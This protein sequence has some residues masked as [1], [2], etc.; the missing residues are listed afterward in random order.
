MWFRE[1]GNAGSGNA[2]LQLLSLNMKCKKKNYIIRMN[3]VE[4]VIILTFYNNFEKLCSLKI[5]SN[6]IIHM[7]HTTL[8]KKW[9]LLILLSYTYVIQTP[10]G[11][12]EDWTD[13]SLHLNS[14]A[15]NSQKP[16]SSFQNL[17]QT[18]CSCTILCALHL[19]VWLRGLPAL[20][21]LLLHA[22]WPRFTL[23][24]PT[25]SKLIRPKPDQPQSPGF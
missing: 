17:L 25:P 7:K 1:P 3:L 23:T 16:S 18:T 5:E 21:A 19:G 15:R 12:L 4:A 8:L 9:N 14:S 13:I 6:E 20:P 10:V 2:I 22:L 11:A 24:V